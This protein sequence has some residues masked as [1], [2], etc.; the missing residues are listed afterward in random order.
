MKIVPAAKYCIHVAMVCALL[1]GGALHAQGV[2]GFSDNTAAYDPREIAMLPPYCKHTQLF[3]EKVPGGNDPGQ[4]ARWQE[5][6]GYSY[7]NLHH[8]CWGLMK[9]NRGAYMARNAQLR[10][11]LLRD[12]ITEYNYVIDRA[13]PGFI[14]MP[15]I[16]T[17]KGENLIRLG[18]G[19]LAV[20]EFERA[21][22]AKP[23]YWPPYAAMGDY[24]LSIGEM[25]M[26]RET[27]ERGL[28]FAPDTSALKRRIDELDAVKGGRP[29]AK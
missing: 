7:I 10:G 17:K 20:V 11:F 19:P 21:A 24:Y 1:G 8:Y 12:A 16:L 18:K 3:R 28:S 26:A 22:E 13:Q 4:I 5:V 23:D 14:L 15:E 9:T 6:M 29:A 27:L 25:K 2:G